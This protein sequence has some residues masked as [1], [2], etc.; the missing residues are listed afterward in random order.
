MGAVIVFEHFFA[1]R[2]GVLPSYAEKSKSRFSL[3]VFLAWLISFGIFYT[4]SIKFDIFLSFLTLPAWI[5]CGIL[6]LILSRYFQ[7]K[8]DLEIEA[9]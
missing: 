7:K 3:P 2:F 9:G 5:S 4:L 8:T 1:E 6:F